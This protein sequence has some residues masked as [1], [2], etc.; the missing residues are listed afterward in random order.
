MSIWV[1]TKEYND[2]NQHGEYYVAAFKE[3]PST[4]MI[5]TIINCSDDMAAWIL[6]G[7]GREGIE[8]VWYN[9]IE[10]K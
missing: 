4:E 6:S 1:L 3:K 5:K 7:G 8:D 2:Y 10:E 9:L